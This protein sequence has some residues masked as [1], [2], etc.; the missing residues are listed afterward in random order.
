MSK[1]KM[2]SLVAL[3]LAA[4]GGVY[5]YTDKTIQPQSGREMVALGDSLT[6]G[7]GDQT[8]QGYADE[9]EER[10]N[11]TQ[12]SPLTVYNY[13]IPGQQTDGLLQ[14]LQD[15]DVKKTLKHAEY[16]TIFIGTNDL[17]KT[18]GGDLNPLYEDRIEAGKADYRK[19]VEKIL[20][21]IRAE[22]P[23]APILFLGLFNPYPESEEIQ[24]VITE[25][26]GL[27][28]ELLA[29]DERVKFIATDGL[30]KEKSTDYFSDALHPNSKGYEL[31]TDE[32]I[33]EYDF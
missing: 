5:W 25:W 20:S 18:N 7:V 32:I 10:L 23:D 9:L 33:R 30:L 22:N 29:D 19:N 6:Y 3:I 31:I 27:T 17:I 26:N 11:E 8:G 12:S 28:Q 24:Q 15:E 4:A 16:F 2:L 13:G 1:F 14:Q 21:M